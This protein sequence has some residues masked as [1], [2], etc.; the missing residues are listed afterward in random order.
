MSQGGRG[1]YRRWCRKG[2][3]LS[4]IKTGS[5]R[6]NSERSAPATRP[7]T[8]PQPK[9][10]VSRTKPKRR[11]EKGMRFNQSE[12]WSTSNKRKWQGLN[13]SAKDGIRARPQT[14]EDVLQFSIMSNRARMQIGNS[15][16][17]FPGQLDRSGRRQSRP[18]YR[19]W[20]KTWRDQR[21]VIL[22]LM[23]LKSIHW[24]ISHPL[25][26]FWPFRKAATFWPIISF[27]P[28]ESRRIAALAGI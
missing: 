26:H 12:I 28:P 21:I 25:N 4:E 16:E 18:I 15:I 23:P 5:A 27:G 2:K 9:R 1:T 22:D 11:D 3:R 20:Q 19:V 14:Q 10:N 7:N 24:A 13:R 6:I 8:V 17:D